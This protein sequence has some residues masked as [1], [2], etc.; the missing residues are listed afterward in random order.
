[1]PNIELEIIKLL[2][3][4]DEFS[5]RYKSTNQGCKSN[6]TSLENLIEQV[7]CC[8][9]ANL[10]NTELLKE[11]PDIKEKLKLKI[12]IEIQ[13]HVDKLKQNL[14]SLNESV[15]KLKKQSHNMRKKLAGKQCLSEIC[16]LS[17]ATATVPALTDIVIWC[18]DALLIADH[19][20]NAKIYVLNNVDEIIAKNNPGELK[21]WFEYDDEFTNKVNEILFWCTCLLKKV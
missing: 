14:E 9:R 15:A 20:L 19:C 12:N 17:S 13:K 4:L 3:L 21:E 10:K 11:F 5:K 6:I 8:D 1:M 2:R 16:K 18:E 7:V